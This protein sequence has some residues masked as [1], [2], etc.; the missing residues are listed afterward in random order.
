MAPSVVPAS[1]KVTPDIQPGHIIVFK[2]CSAA[3]G[4]LTEATTVQECFVTQVTRGD[5]PWAQ[6]YLHV[7]MHASANPG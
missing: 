4:C 6:W 5:A 1:L 3:L 7:L 2:V